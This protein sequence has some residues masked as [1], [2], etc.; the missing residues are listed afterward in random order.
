M[1]DVLEIAHM[2]EAEFTS[3]RA[4]WQLW[5]KSSNKKSALVDPCGGPVWTGNPPTIRQK[6]RDYDSKSTVPRSHT[7]CVR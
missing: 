6:R 3:N 4:T 7:I 2:S 1:T 5:R